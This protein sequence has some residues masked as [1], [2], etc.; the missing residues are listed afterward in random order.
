MSLLR[1]EWV[2]LSRRP[3]NRG[4]AACVVGYMLLEGGFTLLRP[5]ESQPWT[6]FDL[7]G[8]FEQR[9]LGMS[10][11]M[12][13]LVIV[14]AASLV[15][16]EHTFDTLKVVLTR[17]PRRWPLLVVKLGLVLALSTV[18]LLVLQAWS[19]FTLWTVAQRLNVAEHIKP[20]VFTQLGRQ[21]PIIIAGVLFWGVMAFGLS[22]LTRSQVLAIVSSLLLLSLL[23]GAG[24]VPSPTLALFL[25]THH[26]DNLMG[27]AGHAQF[28]DAAQSAFEAEVPAAVSVLVLLGWVALVLV[29]AF[30]VFE[31]RDVA[32]AP[33]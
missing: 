10:F 33:G 22:V 29:P 7:S 24:E 2:R 4:L 11:I 27:L 19:V 23:G 32:G 15:A 12:R 16:S 30:V 13:T 6:V 17:L 3:L 14:L 20:E 26:F 5:R 8:Q 1:S 28:L 21:V 31:R 18:C 25:P 9:L